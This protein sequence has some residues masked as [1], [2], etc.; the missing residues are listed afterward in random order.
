MLLQFYDDFVEDCLKNNIS[1]IKNKPAMFIYQTG[2]AYSSVQNN[3]PQAQ[4]E[5]SIEKSGCFLVSPI[6]FLTESDG[7]HLDS[8][9]Y[10]WL[11][12]FFGKV[13][14]RVIDLN[15]KWLPLYPLKAIVDNDIIKI[16]FH[17]PVPPLVWQNPI[18]GHSRF[19]VK[20]MGF[21]VLDCNGIIDISDIKIF[22]E[23]CVHIS[24]VRLVSVDAY[25][26]YAGAN[27][28]GRGCLRDSDD[29]I[30]YDNYCYREQDGCSL[31][32]SIDE[33]ND[34][35]YPLNNWCVA[36]TIGLN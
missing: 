7:G 26:R 2:G 4:L 35:P 12:A 15:Q 20:D 30:A 27:R 6:Y 3:I 29:E 33:L 1:E 8:N 31:T 10:R 36:F 11:G 34:K 24:L 17:V 19:K 13:L 22:S 28:V 9:G 23:T 16:Y 14:H 18:A 5:I 21:E 25:V 32:V